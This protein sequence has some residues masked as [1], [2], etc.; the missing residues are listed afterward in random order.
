MQKRML[1]RLYNERAASRFGYV[2]MIRQD[3]FRLLVVVTSSQ[4]MEPVESPLPV[5]SAPALYL[6]SAASE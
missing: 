5:K 4:T 6:K 1:P 3:I 2:C